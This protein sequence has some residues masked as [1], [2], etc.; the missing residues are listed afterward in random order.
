M[1]NVSFRYSHSDADCLG[2]LH[3]LV[4]ACV[5]SSVTDNCPTLTYD[6]EHQGNKSTRK[7]P[8]FSRQGFFRYNL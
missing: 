1:F 7:R 2:N 6:A 8:I 4:H 5:Y 3:V